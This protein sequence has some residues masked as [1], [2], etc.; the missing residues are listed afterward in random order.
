[1]P[2]IQITTAPVQGSQPAAGQ[3]AVG[4]GVS[5]PDPGPIAM[6]HHAGLSEEAAKQ[7]MARPGGP[8]DPRLHA[9]WAGVRE[10]GQA[11]PS[12]KPQEQFVGSEP[13]LLILGRI[14]SM[15][16]QLLNRAGRF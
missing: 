3:T 6:P 12:Y 9:A 4:G 2:D 16:S 10:Q 7:Q 11:P 5:P 13:M 14:E 8:T 15:L 1:M